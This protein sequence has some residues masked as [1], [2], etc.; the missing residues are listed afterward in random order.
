VDAAP[1]EVELALFAPAESVMTALLP[2]ASAATPSDLP[3]GSS[4]FAL[5]EMHAL[6]AKATNKM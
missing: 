6:L 1:E 5:A 4:A 3:T 2:P